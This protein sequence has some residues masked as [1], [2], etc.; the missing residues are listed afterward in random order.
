MVIWHIKLYSLAAWVSLVP[1]FIPSFSVAWERGYGL[2][3]LSMTAVNSY[4]IPVGI[5]YSQVQGEIETRIVAVV[6]SSFEFI[7][8]FNESVATLWP[9]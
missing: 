2:A 6:N 8:E 4:R 9:G 1:R 7:F 5:L 3:M